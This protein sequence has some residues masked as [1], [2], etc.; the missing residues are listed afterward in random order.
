MKTLRLHAAHDLR[1]HEEPTPVPGSGDALLRVK[2]VGICG[3]DLHWYQ[4]GGIGD[5]RLVHPLV[6]GHEFTAVTEAGERVAV[7]PSIACGQCEYCQRGDPNLCEDLIFAGHGNHDGALRQQIAWPRRGLFPISDRLSEAEGVMLEPLGVAMHAVN[8]GKLWVGMNV[9]VFGVG[10]IGLLVLQLVRLSGAETIVVTD[11][12]S[13]RLE[14]ARSLGATSAILA[15]AE[16][17]VREVMAATGGRGVNVAFEVAGENEAVET[18][19]ASVRPGGRVVLIG[20]PGDDRTSFSAST[21]RRKGLTL[22]LLRRMKHIYPDA[23]RLV[24][25]GQVEVRS[26]VTHTF[27]FEQA[28]DAFALAIRREGLKVVILL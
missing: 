18:S 21:A 12:L 7:E 10:P 19:I 3:S 8:L 25:S 17:E 23:I 11:K 1:F 24:E 6:L 26:L 22:I 13:H 27:Q 14:A 5:A 2:S 9:G 16:T 20:I 15:G 28:A 4:E